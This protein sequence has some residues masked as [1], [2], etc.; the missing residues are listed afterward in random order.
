MKSGRRFLL[1]LLGF[2]CAVL[3]LGIVFH[4]KASIVG[5]LLILPVIAGAIDWY[6]L[7]ATTTALVSSFVFLLTYYH[8]FSFEE[9]LIVSFCYIAIGILF[10]WM[11]KRLA[12]QKTILE[13]REKR[14]EQLLVQLQSYLD[15]AHSVILFLNKDGKVAFINKRGCELLGYP[16]EEIL[17]KD[18]FE[19]FLPKDTAQEVKRHLFDLQFRAEIT[20][21]YENAVLTKDGKE[22]LILWFNEVLRNNEGDLIGILSNGVDV[23]ELGHAKWQLSEQ[24]AATRSLYEMAESLITESLDLR[25]RAQLV[26]KMCVEKLGA[27]VAL[28]GHALP[29]RSIKIIAQFPEDPG[30]KDVVLRWDDTPYARGLAGESIKTEKIQIIE[31]IFRS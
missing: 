20:D 1:L 28:V 4:L 31:D 17:G 25:K 10:G 16:R 13:E 7:G 24:L 29:D 26:S 30:L 14:Y 6:V 2:Y 5:S 18:W 8:Q 19:N 15:S 9:F 3:I 12:R 11:A 21:L 23:T 27:R 22:R